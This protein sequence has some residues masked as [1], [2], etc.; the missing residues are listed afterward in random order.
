MI[1]ECDGGF[2][3]FMLGHKYIAVYDE[4]QTFPDSMA[5]MKIQTV[6]GAESIMTKTKTYAGSFCKR[7]G[8][9]INV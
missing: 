4:S 8:R 7:C 3:G 9:T 6:A 2:I 1:G 5:G